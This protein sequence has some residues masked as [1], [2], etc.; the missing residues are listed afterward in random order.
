MLVQQP[1]HVDCVL[2]RREVHDRVRFDETFEAA[3]DLDYMLR[4]AMITPIVELDLVL[5]VHGASTERLSAISVERRIAGRKRFREKHSALFD[6]EA[7]AFYDLRL[8]R[9]LLREGRRG[10][11]AIAFIR[12]LRRRPASKLA[13]KGLGTVVLGSA[14][15]SRIARI[16]D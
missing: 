3:A 4:V 8:G 15:V 12:S 7:A 9:L 13:W 6:D 10:E 1:P 16:V 5:A 2:V 14:L 11:A